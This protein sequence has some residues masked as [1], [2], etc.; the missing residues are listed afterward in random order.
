MDVMSM[1]TRAIVEQLHEAY[2]NGD[3]ERVAAL[4]HDDIDWCIHGP[5]RI[6]PFEG[7][8]RGKAQVMEVLTAIGSQ[9]EL[10]RYEPEI[11]IVEGD[12]A[13]TLVNTS[14]EQRATGRLLSLRLVN[15]LRIQDG[16]VIE[17]KE[18]SDTFDVVEQAMGSWLEVPAIAV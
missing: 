15:F 12:R 17:F 9:Y 18:F 5:A 3:G 1:D 11:V 6:F 2:R 13:A 4:V 10:K 14:F 16:Q 7:P 8:R